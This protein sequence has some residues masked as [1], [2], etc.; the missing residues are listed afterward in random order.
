MGQRLND[1]CLKIKRAPSVAKDN[2]FAFACTVLMPLSTYCKICN[3]LRGMGIGF[4]LGVA[5]TV[6]A[7][8][9]LGKF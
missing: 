3:M 5:L 7:F 9:A 4:L 8:Y 1:I 6:A 2:A